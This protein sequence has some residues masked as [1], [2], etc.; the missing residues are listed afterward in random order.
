MVLD[1]R[2]GGLWNEGF[3][4]V[5]SRVGV[6]GF[7]AITLAATRGVYGHFPPTCSSPGWRIG[8]NLLPLRM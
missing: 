5:F 4:W 6:H 7:V 1:F 8:D 2:E 3:A